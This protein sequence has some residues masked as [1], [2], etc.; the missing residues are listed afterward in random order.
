MLTMVN[1][2][3]R[4]RM[5]FSDLDSV[6]NQQLLLYKS[7]KEFNEK[8]MLEESILDHCFWI[9]MFKVNIFIIIEMDWIDQG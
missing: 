7:D 1:M 3:N 4:L 9:D 5:C 6:E 2:K 8:R